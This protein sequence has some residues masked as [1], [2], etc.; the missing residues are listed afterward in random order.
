MDLVSPGL[1]I[2]ALLPPDLTTTKPQILLF[3]PL[4]PILPGCSC[5]EDLTSASIL[6]LKIM[7]WFSNLSRTPAFVQQLRLCCECLSQGVR[8]TQIACPPQDTSLLGPL[9]GILPPMGRVGTTA[10]YLLIPCNLLLC[11]NC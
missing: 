6:T 3:L 11:F 10:A 2:S 4:T 5:P 7:S 1:L 9:A 8:G